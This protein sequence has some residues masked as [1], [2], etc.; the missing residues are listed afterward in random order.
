MPETLKNY[1]DGKWCESEADDYVNV[2]N[3]ATE[4]VVARVALAGE[5]EVNAAVSAARRAFA[6][7]S[8]FTVAERVD[9][10][11][12]VAARMKERA[13]EIAQAITTEMGAPVGL[14]KAAQFGAALGQFE[15]TIKILQAFDFEEEMGPHRIV[16]EPIGVCALITPW[17]W[18]VALSII[19]IA[20][21]LAAGCTMVHKPSEISPLSAEVFAKVL[22]DAGVPAGVYNLVHGD[23]PGVGTLLSK[24]PDVDMVSFTGSTRAGVF[25]AQNAAPT[26]KRV[27]QEL[28]GKSPN[29]IAESADVAAA[30]KRGVHQLL[31]NSGQS[32]N[33]PS[34]MLVPASALAEAEAAATAAL[35]KVVSGDPKEQ[36][37]TLGPVASKAQYDKVQR[38]IQSALD[39]GA[40]LVVGG[41]GKPEGLETG[42]HIKP[43]ILSDVT[44]DMSIA[45]EEVFGPVLVMI[46]YSGLDEAIDIANDTDYGLA[47]YV[48]AG[49]REE[50]VSIARRLRAG[51]VHLNGASPSPDLP[52][53]G[54]KK[55]GNG[56]EWGKFGLEEYL[57]IKAIAGFSD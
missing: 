48:Q 3:P 37:T 17:N 41:P 40:R 4:E 8:N 45:R 14:A 21:A 11:E 57:E 2:V 25:V 24:H 38:L 52:F 30:V 10:M 35:E 29:I 27:T 39:E 16:R 53:G 15:H 18:P 28:G 44:N 36:S 7:Y 51:N 43:T 46:P 20:P 47:G 26:V 12:S 42:F 31:V 49:T 55:S 6:R 5:A 22:D 13:S 56:R 34:R 54:Y 33:A 1:I 32:C 50:A 9:L 23:G 19:K